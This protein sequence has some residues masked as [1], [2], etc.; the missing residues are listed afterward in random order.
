MNK[1]LYPLSTI[2]RN[3]EGASSIGVA[4]IRKSSPSQEEDFSCARFRKDKPERE[5]MLR[6]LRDNNE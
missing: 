4:Y 2:Q 6:T 1:K 5:N 3:S